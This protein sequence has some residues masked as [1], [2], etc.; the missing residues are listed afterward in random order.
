MSTGLSGGIRSSGDEVPSWEASK[1]PVKSKHSYCSGIFC[2][3]SKILLKDLLLS[4]TA[5]GND[6]HEHLNPHGRG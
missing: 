5:V 3:C 2:P 6:S 1:D 4:M